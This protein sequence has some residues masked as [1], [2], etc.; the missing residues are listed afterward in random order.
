MQ[1]E[2]EVQVQVQCAVYSVHCAVCSVLLGFRSS[3]WMSQRVS[4]SLT[5]EPSSTFLENLPHT[6][7]NIPSTNIEQ[8]YGA[9][10][11]YN[12]DRVQTLRLVLLLEKVL[13]QKSNF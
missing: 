6:N 5:W 4:Y 2:V 10:Y 3:N 9:L 11:S 1:V 13:R 8:K 12:K 7:Q